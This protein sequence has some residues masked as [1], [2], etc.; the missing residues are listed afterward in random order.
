MPPVSRGMPIGREA[1]APVMATPIRFP[2]N[3]HELSTGRGNHKGPPR[4]PVQ[5]AISTS[6]AA[7]IRHRF[8]PIQRSAAHVRKPSPRR[9]AGTRDDRRAADTGSGPPP[10]G[11]GT[12][13]PAK[14][15]PLANPHAPR[16]DVK[17]PTVE[18]AAPT[19]A[20]MP[21]PGFP[22]TWPDGNG[23]IAEILDG[24]GK[25]PLREVAFTE[26][27]PRG[28]RSVCRARWPPA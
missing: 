19:G 10:V 28:E 26:G 9:T 15:P 5:M 22:R 2:S 21:P 4:S 12:R 17:S 3:P 18:S 13:W 16:P 20:R 14:S 1:S 24:A 23:G 11:R 25:P 6:A 7:I 27:P 8:P